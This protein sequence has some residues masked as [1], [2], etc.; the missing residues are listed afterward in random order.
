MKDNV[1][2]TDKNRTDEK[3]LVVHGVILFVSEEV[4]FCKHEKLKKEETKCG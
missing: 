3:S 2:K 4:F 1:D